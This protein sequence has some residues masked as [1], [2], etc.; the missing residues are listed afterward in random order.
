M[1]AVGGVR[2][3]I[4]LVAYRRTGEVDA[5]DEYSRLLVDA[6]RE[7]GNLVSYTPAGIPPA[8]RLDVGLA[9][10]LVQYNP[11]SYGRWGVAPG[12]VHD[13]IAIRRRLAAPL[14]VMVH[15]SWVETHDWKSALVG[16]WQRMQLKSLSRIATVLMATNQTTARQLGPSS[17]H[18]PPGSN[19][20][21]VGASF[22]TARD[23]LGLGEDL[24]VALFGRGNPSRALDHAEAAIDAIADARDPHRIRVFNLGADAPSLQANPAIRVV[25][26]GKMSAEQL[27]LHLWASD[28]MLLPLTNGLSTGRTTL[29]A[30]LAH[31]LPVLGL[32]GR[33]TE[34]VLLER[35]DIITL[36]PVGDRDAFSHAAADLVTD[37]RRLRAR[38]QA[39]RRFYLEHFDWPH[40]ARRVMSAIENA[41]AAATDPRRCGRRGA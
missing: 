33:A 26:P 27:S 18:I 16:T 37:R 17:V 35:A 25:R 3:R 31:G 7:R 41:T 40:V 32:R 34:D 5:I 13:A 1:T 6:L 24:V 19:I 29:M 21:P 9:W 15:E 30:A 8:R 20:T 39:G 10:V 11:F 2:D 28:L 14:A 22:E 38:G 36:T 12:I 23:R 4:G